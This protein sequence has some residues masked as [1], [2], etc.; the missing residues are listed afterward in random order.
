[1]VLLWKSVITPVI[2]QIIGAGVC[3]IRTSK[4]FQFKIPKLQH[5]TILKPNTIS[6]GSI[7]S[8]LSCIHGGL[9]SLPLWQVDLNR[10]PCSVRYSYC[11][12]SITI[13]CA[14][15]GPVSCPAKHLYSNLSKQNHFWSNGRNIICADVKYNTEP[16][17]T[18]IKFI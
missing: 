12:T 18:I 16:V 17:F 13:D 8:E 5:R 10:I 7:N 9:V 14:L 15:E 11:A 3:S 6:R 2:F 1:M 4:I